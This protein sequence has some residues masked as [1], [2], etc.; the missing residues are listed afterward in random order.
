MESYKNSNEAPRIGDKVKLWPGYSGYNRPSGISAAAIYTVVDGRD[1]Q[2]SYGITVKT[3]YGS[4]TTLSASNFLVVERAEVSKLS[5][6]NP[7]M[8]ILDG[9]I[10]SSHPDMDHAKAAAVAMLTKNHKLQVVI[11]EVQTV[12]KSKAPP[13][14]FV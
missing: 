14:E 1:F 7:W 10:V 4:L 9:K 3:D 5:E 12:A 13:V 2:K 8:C 6:T 11:A